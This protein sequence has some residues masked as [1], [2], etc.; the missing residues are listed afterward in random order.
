MVEMN[1]TGYSI[2]AC[3]TSTSIG[4]SE[5][6]STS[7]CCFLALLIIET[8]LSYSSTFFCC[9]ADN[10]AAVF[11]CGTANFCTG[12]W[13]EERSAR[14]DLILAL[15]SLDCCAISSSAWNKEEDHHPQSKNAPTF[16]FSLASVFAFSNS[17]FSCLRNSSRSSCSF[18]RSTSS[19]CF[20]SSS[21]ARR[22]FSASASLASWTS[23]SNMSIF[24]CCK[25]TI[26]S[27][28]VSFLEEEEED[29]FA[30][31]SSSSSSLSSSSSAA[32][33]D[34]LDAFFEEEDL[35]SLC[36]SVAFFSKNSFCVG[37]IFVPSSNSPSF[38][39]ISFAFS[40]FFSSFFETGLAAV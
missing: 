39:F 4:F 30:S 20:A 3:T 18:S 13:A 32:A 7:L 17:S 27:S 35:D 29:F 14:L 36:A 33:A 16:F 1:C 31:V 2:L 37:V 24:S 12:L 11:L 9:S 25:R 38:C 15:S 23:F 6:I 5:E 34:F 8:S 40:C 22:S 21:V 26:F 28:A 10:F 19:L